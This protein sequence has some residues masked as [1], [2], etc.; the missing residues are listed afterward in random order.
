MEK[1]R[2]S[3]FK[4]QKL[5]AWRP[6]PTYCMTIALFGIFSTIF[7]TLGAIMLAQSNMI[8]SISIQYSTDCPTIGSTCDVS[9]EVKDDIEGPVYVYYELDNFYQNHRRYVKSRS[10]MQLRGEDMGYD[11]V[12]VDCDPAITNSD[13]GKL[14]SVNGTVLNG[15]DV[16]VPCGLIAK[17]YF[18]DIFQ[19]S[20]VAPF[21]VAQ[22]L[23]IDSSEIAWKSDREY[24]FINQGEGW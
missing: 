9:F 7:I 15:D 8:K 23:A 14:V 5:P 2:A 13:I 16:A 20:S 17:T 22:E 11:D 21:S 18:N 19:L 1:L 10:I 4:Q 12:K 6:V 24:K 3:A